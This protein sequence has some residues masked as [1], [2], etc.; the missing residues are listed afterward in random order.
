MPPA[1]ARRVIRWPRTS[2]TTDAQGG[3]FP[4]PCSSSTGRADGSPVPDVW[5]VAAAHPARPSVTSPPVRGGLFP[6]PARETEL[7]GGG[8]VAE[9]SRGGG[10]GDP[11]AW[12][13]LEGGRLMYRKAR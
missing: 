5:A 12:T 6:R 2:R 4:R 8:D 13:S 9:P 3:W 11:A 1:Y 7:R 10:C